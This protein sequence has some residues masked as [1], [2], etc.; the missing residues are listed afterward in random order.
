MMK[1]KKKGGGNT[2]GN[3]LILISSVAVSISLLRLLPRCCLCVS[4]RESACDDPIKS[5]VKAMKAMGKGMEKEAR[6]EGGRRGGGGGGLRVCRMLSYT[7]SRE[8]R[9]SELTLC[10]G[11]RARAQLRQFSSPIR[12]RPIERPQEEDAVDRQTTAAAVSKIKE[13]M[14]LVRCCKFPLFVTLLDQNWHWVDLFL[15]LGVV[16]DRRLVFIFHR[17]SAVNDERTY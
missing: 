12:K 16:R 8:R 17:L 9:R 5:S 7:K 4:V 1:T 2:T 11:Y 13:E 10:S 14:V 3:D 6:K 15:S